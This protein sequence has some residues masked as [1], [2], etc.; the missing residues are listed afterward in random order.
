M[1]LGSMIFLS[2]LLLAFLASTK[3]NLVSSKLYAQ[4]T[5]VKLLAETAVNLV[6]LQ[7]RSATS[8]QTNKTWASQPGAIRTYDNTG[9]QDKIY[10]LYSSDSLLVSTIDPVAEVGALANWYNDT[11]IFTDLNAPVSGHYPIFNPAAATGSTAVEG[12]TIKSAPAAPSVGGN[13][14]PMPVRWL[15][16]LQN[17]AI[18]SPSGSGK[19]ATVSGASTQNQIVA[20]IA[21]WTDDDSCKIN[22]NTASESTY[23]DT[24][25][26]QTSQD[27]A[28]ASYQPAQKEFQRYSGHPSTVCLSTVF[29]ALTANQIYAIAPRVVEGGSDRGT[30][31]APTAL[32]PDGDRLYCS[33]DELVVKPNRDLNAGLDKD[34]V[35]KVR[36]CLTAQSKAP[37]VNLF[38]QPRIAIWPIRKDPLLSSSSAKVTVFDKL[39][40]FCSTVNGSPYYFQRE[41]YDSPTH[42]ISIQRNQELLG[43]LEKLT[44]TEIPGFGGNFQIKYGDDRDQI[45][46]EIFD[47]IRCSNLNDDLLTSGNQFTP[48]FGSGGTGSTN[49]S[50]GHGWAAPSQWNGTAGLGRAYSLSELGIIFIC[51]AVADDPATSGIDESSGSNTTAN[52]V[53]GGTLLT[54]GQKYVQA[55]IVPEFFCAMQGWTGCRPEMRIRITGLDNLQVNGSSLGFPADGSMPYSDFNNIPNGRAWGGGANWRSFGMALDGSVSVGGAPLGNLPGDGASANAPNY[56]FISFPV[57][58]SG[59]PASGGTMAFTGGVIT[60]EFYATTG[61]ASPGNL[62]QKIKVKLPDGTFPI[63]NIVTTGTAAVSSTPAT[64]KETWW[65]FCKKGA[66]S[67]IRGRLNAVRNDTSVTGDVSDAGAGGVFIRNDFDTVRT[68]LPRHGDYR[69]IAGISTLDDSNGSI[70]VR[71]PYYDDPAR[72]NA[73]LYSGY[74]AWSAPGLQSPG[75]YIS[76]ANYSTDQVPDIPSTA[77]GTDTPESTGDFDNGV[78]AAPDGPYVNKP[79]EGNTYRNKPSDVPYF[80]NN[81][82]QEG[83]G[84]TFFSPNRMLPSP[85]MFGS[86]PTGI[87]QS[88]PWQTLLFR[89]QSAHPGSASPKDHLLMDLFWMPVVE[90]YAISEPFA[91]AGKINM[92]YQ[93]LPFSYMERSTGIRAAL[94]AEKIAAIPTAKGLTYKTTTGGKIMSDVFRLEI[95]RNET[96]KQFQSLFDSGKIFRSATEICDL[97]IVPNGKTVS[98]MSS[99]WTS[100]ALTGDNLREKIYTTLYAKLTTKSNVFTVHYRV[101]TLLKPQN[102]PNPDK[103]I[104]GTHVITGEYRG[105]TTLERYIDPS[106]TAIPDYA[107]ASNPPGL[108]Q[109][110]KFRIISSTQFNP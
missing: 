57:K 43:Y 26:V 109:F 27:Y 22:I 97:H 72:R 87:K 95:D 14:A 76:G 94:K 78:A 7:I 92:N 69:L 89:P 96:L 23:W 49:Y 56:P 37:E 84:S 100:H 71:H 62:I 24:P 10:R 16:V 75:R 18:V 83:L 80:S 90:P 54:A 108:D 52:L 107:K 2:A 81:Q 47:Y 60:I 85:G 13:A 19:N 9:Q 106:D 11:A 110:Y 31:V 3:S 44:S 51:N 77:T 38:N 64:T 63:P 8:G 1:V 6:Q 91:T 45:L 36:F 40:A 98:A 34:T 28:L 48:G 32:T 103:W 66:V 30:A 46:T 68:I 4:G 93:I 73:S 21:F 42:D 104:E 55:I 58:L 5:S 12:L 105:S 41:Q 99:F 67:G 65:A 33:V 59:I 53:L 39:I 88:A 86:L 70:F 50:P 35:D 79:D 74:L 20:R 25:R 101:Q 102:D 15:Y 82:K 61:A 29:P 17:G